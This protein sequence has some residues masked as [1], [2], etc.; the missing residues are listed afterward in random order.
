MAS[1]SAKVGEQSNVNPNF[2]KH[3]WYRNVIMAWN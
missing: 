2:G 1:A 3:C